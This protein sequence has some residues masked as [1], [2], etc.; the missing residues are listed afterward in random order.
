MKRKIIYIV[1]LLILFLLLFNGNQSFVICKEKSNNLTDFGF[2]D[3]LQESFNMI[4]EFLIS[5]IIRIIPI[6]VLVIIIW[7]MF[8][9][10][11]RWSKKRKYN[12]KERG[13]QKKIDYLN[14]IKQQQRLLHQR[15][16][17]QNRL[18]PHQQQ[19]IS[20]NPYSG[21]PIINNYYGSVNQNLHDIDPDDFMERI[22]KR[23]KVLDE[24]NII[25]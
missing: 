15:Q 9:L 21:S 10:F 17:I 4:I 13:F 24:D 25:E 23:K 22:K 5:L 6:I 19:P 20:T 8:K 18:P 1:Y 7:I 12:K 2:L 16:V 14:K 11:K 3:D